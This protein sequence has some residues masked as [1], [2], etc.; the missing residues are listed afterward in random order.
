[1]SMRR[2]SLSAT[3]GLVALL[4]LMCVAAGCGYVKNVRDDL[5]DVGSFAIGGVPPVVPFSEGAQAVGPLPPAIGVYVELTEF[6]H[7]GY[8][9]KATGD[10]QWDRRSL[11]TMIDTRRKVGFG[12]FHS[13][14]IKQE[15]IC[16]DAY[17]TP[18]GPMEAWRQHMADL[19]DPLFQRDAKV[20]IYEPEEYAPEMEVSSYETYLRIASGSGGGGMAETDESLPFL[21]RGWQDWETISVEVAVPEP[22]LLHSGFYIGVGCDPSQVFDLALSLLCIDIYD[23]AAYEFWSGD[24]R[25]LTDEQKAQRAAAEKEEEEETEEPSSLDRFFGAGEP[26]EEE[27]E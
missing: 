22:F 12:P 16:A 19:K 27:E 25:F 2:G 20:L 14:T 5:L 1:M 21:Y 7:F 17:K 18:G 23:D 4:S 24:Y 10:I 11:G 26:E 15:P 13:V 6:L 3:V 8:L 9:Y